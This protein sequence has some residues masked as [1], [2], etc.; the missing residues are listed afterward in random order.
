[1]PVQ[2]APADLPVL[3]LYQIEPEWDAD[4]TE[5]VLDA[6]TKM[7][8]ALQ[9]AGHAVYSAELRTSDLADVLAAF[10]P[11]DVIVFNQ[12]ESLPGVPQSEHEAAQI[13]ADLGFTYTGATPEVIAL[14][15]D[16]AATKNILD[17][18]RIPTPA[19]KVFDHPSADGWTAYP[20][21][22][23]TLRE[24][25]SISLCP[26]SVVMNQAELET[27]IEHILRVYHQPALVEDFI[28]GR[29]FHVPLW[30][31]GQIQMLPVVEM[32]FSAFRDIQDRL[33]T[34]DSKF[35]PASRHYNV[36]Q[37][38]IPAP[39]SPAEHACLQQVCID[40][41]RAVG[42]RDCAR[43]DVRMRDGV[44]YI[45]DVNPNADL[46]CDA[47]IACAAEHAGWSYEAMMTRLV[48]LA[49]RRHPRFAS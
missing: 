1:M 36:I 46:D 40:T 23:K 18:H 26:E 12:C 4:D 49:A 6:N 42:C 44:F 14:T 21:I 37:T 2:R 13:I 3:Y 32:D 22:V 39:L 29:E 30:G 27:R 15:N 17:E 19:W 24:H 16:K 9:Q 8:A 38:L 43:L 7:A 20:A 25:C 34:Y 11:D 28:D 45:L 5:A 31:N 47:S 33:C 48:H 10:S 41:Y 35:D